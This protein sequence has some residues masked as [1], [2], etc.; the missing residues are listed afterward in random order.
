M[1]EDTR[2][3]LFTL[4]EG[5]YHLGVAALINSAHNIGYAGLCVVGYRGPIPPWSKSIALSNGSYKAGNIEVE[6]VAS[7]PQMHFGYFKPFFACELLKR[8]PK[9]SALIYADPDVL[10][11]APWEFFDN[12]IMQGQAIG[13]CA[14]QNFP[15]VSENHPWRKYWRILAEAAGLSI[16]NPSA[17]YINSGFVGVSE[18]RA[19]LWKL[20]CDVTLAYHQQGGDLSSFRM[21]ERWRSVV[22]DQDL[23]AATLMSLM[24]CP[25]LLGQEGMGFNGDFKFLC[26]VI[27]QPKPWRDARAWRSAS[28]H[29]PSSAFRNWR[30]NYEGPINTMGHLA[31][32]VRKVDFVM[33]TAISRVYRRF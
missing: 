5:D 31:K 13:L 1:T 18:T 23:L 4:C 8:Y 21:S 6:F 22:S 20:W 15:I 7:D 32:L 25:S 19:S 11:L 3:I 17:P 30:R 10:F 33:S 2:P 9:T 26:H 28:G 12:W 29:A 14:D 16:V 27:E 24:D